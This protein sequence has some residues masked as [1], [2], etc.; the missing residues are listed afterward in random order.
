MGRRGP[1]KKPAEIKRLEGNPGQRVIEAS[2]IEALGEPFVVEHISDDAQG[3]I[4]A[5][6]VSM[7]AK[8]YSALDSFL[9]AA[10]ATAWAIHKRASEETLKPDFNW[11]FTSDAGVQKPSPWV[12]MLNDQARL[13]AMLGSRLGLDPA[14]RAGLKLPSAKQQESKFEGLLGGRIGSSGS[15]NA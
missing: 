5:I 15:L 6:K 14:A 2:G 12:T 8:V 7:P 9:L 4:E 3:C 10:F 1:Q 11:I 13:M